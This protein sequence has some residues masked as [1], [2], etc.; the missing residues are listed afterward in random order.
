MENKRRNGLLRLPICNRKG[1]Y[2]LFTTLGLV[3][4]LMAVGLSL[5]WGS[6]EDRGYDAH[7]DRLSWLKVNH[8]VSNVKSILSSLLRE[9]FYS[10]IAPVGEIR[11]G[12]VNGYLTGSKEEGWQRI[13]EDVKSRASLTLSESLP[14]LADYSD[15]RQSFFQLE[16]GINITIGEL[17]PES[18]SI[19][20]SGDE[21]IGIVTLPMIATSDYQGWEATLFETN[22][23]IPLG[24]RLKDMYERAWE[25]NKNYEEN[26]KWL[27][28]GFIYARAYFNAYAGGSGPFLE[29]GHFDFDPVGALLFGDYTTIKE[30]ASS[31]LAVTDTGAVPVSTWAAET[32][33]LSEPSFLPPGFDISKDDEEQ[34]KAAISGAFASEEYTSG[35]CNNLSGADRADCQTLYDTGRLRGTIDYIKEQEDAYEAIADPVEEWLGTYDMTDYFNCLSCSEER[36]FCRATC[37]AK[38]KTCRSKCTTKACRTKCNTRYDNCRDHCDEDYDNCDPDQKEK[39]REKELDKL[40]PETQSEC[41]G[42]RDNTKSLLSEV[43]DLMET[44]D[45]GQCEDKVDYTRDAYTDDADAEGDAEENFEA[46]NE[47]Y[48]LSQTE[49]ACG[50]FVGALSDIESVLES[51]LDNTDISDSKCSK[52]SAKGDCLFDSE[53]N[54]EDDC[55]VTCHLPACPGSGYSYECVGDKPLGYYKNYECEVC[56]DDGDCRDECDQIDQCTCRC[57]PSRGLLERLFEDLTTIDMYLQRVTTAIR[58]NREAF[59]D[60]LER[61]ENLEELKDKFE[62]TKAEKLGYDVFSRIDPD[63]VKYDPGI[64]KKCYYGNEFADRE[65]G[66]CG[67]SV[68]SIITYTIQVA[69]ASFVGA[70]AFAADFFP[71]FFEAEAKYNL[72]ETLIDDGN[73]VMLENVAGE[74][75]ELY[76]YAPFEFQIYKNREFSLGS[77]TF[78]RTIVYVYL[79]AVKGGLNRVLD[80]LASSKCAG[81]KCD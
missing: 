40:F 26:V 56:D 23:S 1:F 54:D 79:K 46:N 9:G 70:T 17:V 41:S 73:R 3:L 39:C 27:A 60:Q 32:W 5:Q 8:A 38:L 49:A 75:G 4:I 55:D 63:F 21:A 18:F 37:S 24:I 16:E 48:G 30:F 34:L 81:T 11:N 43:S 42:F 22:M 77:A 65:N 58:E 57:R 35:A 64:E 36:T 66:I 62:D 68:E 7:I 67:D 6:Q 61:Q 45:P 29:K 52:P 59:E 76:T 28:S 20:E 19:V 10:A 44:I 14:G 2:P 47:S 51:D 12:T 15:G 13:V 72:T 80:G 53:C 69:L 25:F 50:A 33:Y 78:G 31:P 71:M 74:G